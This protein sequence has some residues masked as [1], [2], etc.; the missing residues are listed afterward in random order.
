M[1]HRLDRPV[2]GVVLFAK[3]SKALSRLNLLFREKKIKKT[4]WAVVKNK[5]KKNSDTLTHYLLKDPKKNKSRAFMK[6]EKGLTVSIDIQS[7]QAPRQFFSIGS[8]SKNRKASS[9]SS[10]IS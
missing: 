8:Q 1:V 4:Y 10:T 9:N 5:P 3:T 7:Y 2:S 6:E